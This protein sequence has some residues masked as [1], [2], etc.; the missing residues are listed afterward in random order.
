MKLAILEADILRDDLIDRYDGYGRMFRDLFSR[1]APDWQT[2]VFNVVRG[3]YPDI[4]RFDAFLV[5][6][7]QHDA[8]SDDPWVEELRNFCRHCHQRDNHQQEKVLLGI[9][10]GHQLLAHALGGTAERSG[11]GWGLGLMTYRQC[12]QPPFA[13]DDGPV[14]LLISHRDQVSELPPDA[15]R[16]LSNDFCANAAFY[17]PGKV[18]CFQGHPEFSHQY[19]ADLMAGRRGQIDSEVFAAA[20]KSMGAVHEGDRVAR[21]MV[22]FVEA[23]PHSPGTLAGQ[24]SS[25]QIHGV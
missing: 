15:R 22:R 5:T 11:N 16:L 12:E 23:A 19:L 20:E 1:T 25:P 18:L 4:D 6:G 14:S 7:S 21:W 2:S 8:F 24:G 9:C 10:F 17:I 13:D 3:H